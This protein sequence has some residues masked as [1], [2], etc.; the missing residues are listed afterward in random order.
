MQ[1]DR[2]DVA[3][4][5]RFVRRAGALCGLFAVV[6][7]LSGC[8]A[9]SEPYFVSVR[10]D[11]HE[12][13]VL[14]DCVSSDCSQVQSPRRVNPGQSSGVG[15]EIDGGYGPAI[16]FGPGH[17]TIGCLPFRMSERPETGVNVVISQVVPCGSSGGVQSVS[18][19]DWPDPRL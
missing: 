4:R 2:Q 5:C 14:A 3:H 15:V 6:F 19:R 11:L 18:G 1:V 12:P 9:F 13:V 7:G 10:N 17:V 16:V 8:A